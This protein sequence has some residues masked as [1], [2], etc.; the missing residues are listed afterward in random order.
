MKVKKENIE[1]DRQVVAK[2]ERQTDNSIRPKPAG[3]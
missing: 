2:P 1:K 3:L